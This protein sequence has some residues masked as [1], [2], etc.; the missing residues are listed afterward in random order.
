MSLLDKYGKALVPAAIAVA[1]AAQA[2]LTDSKITTDEVIA[3]LV[4]VNA[5]V[6][7]YIV[8]ILHYR[9]AK[10]AVGVINAV[11][12]ALAT[13]IVG[14]LN[15]HDTVQLILAALLALG[16]KTARA[17][18]DRVVDGEVVGDVHDEPYRL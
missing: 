9:W 4:A 12:M 10:T 11:L 17:E 1:T 6:S 13:V 5:T 14:G 7:V 3:F 15:A 8:P 18:S 2:P 16:V